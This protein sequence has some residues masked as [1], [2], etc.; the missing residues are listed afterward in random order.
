[1][2]FFVKIVGLENVGG[3]HDGFTLDE[4]AAQNRHLGF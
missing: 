4:H 3:F 1:V 2:G